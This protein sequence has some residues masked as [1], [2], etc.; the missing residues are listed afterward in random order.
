[1][2]KRRSDGSGLGWV[3]AVVFTVLVSPLLAADRPAVRIHVF[4]HHQELADGPE[5]KAREKEAEVRSEAARKA[6]KEVT[7]ALEAQYGKNSRSWPEE[8]E[9]RATE[10]WRAEME[11]I[12]VH[13]E[14]KTSQKDVQGAANGLAARLGDR[15]KESPPVS[16]VESADQADFTVEVLALRAKTSFP[17]AA[18]FVYL[19]VAPLRLGGEG[20]LDATDFGQFRAKDGRV[21]VGLLAG[22]TTR[23]AVTTFHPYT[24]A[25]PYWLV[26]VVQQGTT[27]HGLALDTAAEALAA[28]S[29]GLLAEGQA[30]VAQAAR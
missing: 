9:R 23:G 6:R 19:K 7:K 27:G 21:G 16:V 29:N 26:E 22:A 13:H 20:R 25:E 15:P 24:A 18:W 8:A 1:M 5:R 4:A 17:A 30:A 12:L 28:V 10:A 11:G 14:I 2:G 3:V